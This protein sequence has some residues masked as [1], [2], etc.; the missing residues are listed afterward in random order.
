MSQPIHPCRDPLAAEDLG[1]RGREVVAVVVEQ[2]VAVPSEFSPQAVLDH[3]HFFLR[4]VGVADEDGLSEAELAFHVE[5]LAEDLF[6]ARLHVEDAGL[7]VGVAPVAELRAVHLDAGVENPK[8]DVGRVLVDLVHVVDVEE[9]GFA[10]FRY[11][12]VGV[13]VLAQA[14]A[15]QVAGQRFGEHLTGNGVDEG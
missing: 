2:V 14:H 3:V 12:L 6:V 4:E 5:V 13:D 1:E 10:T 15:G 11:R 8:A 9:D 7:G